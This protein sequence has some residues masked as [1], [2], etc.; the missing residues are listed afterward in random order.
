MF[1]KELVTRKSF[2]I[3]DFKGIIVNNS[4]YITQ[5]HQTRV[6]TNLSFW[7]Y[8]DKHVKVNKVNSIIQVI[9]IPQIVDDFIDSD[10][11]YVNTVGPYQTIYILDAN[12]FEYDEIT[13]SAKLVNYPSAVGHTL[14]ESKSYDMRNLTFE[15]DA[16]EFVV[17]FY[18][19]D[20]ESEGGGGL[21]KDKYIHFLFNTLNLEVV[22]RAAKDV[23]LTSIYGKLLK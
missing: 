16:I 22:I 9:Y 2:Q 23:S 19:T 20:V 8:V 17:Y 6:K 21:I 3:I 7:I 18:E 10:P 12:I 4:Y 1:I 13:F 11:S 14:I 15:G 5:N